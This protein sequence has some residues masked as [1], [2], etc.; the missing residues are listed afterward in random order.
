MDDKRQVRLTKKGTPLTDFALRLSPQ[1]ATKQGKR[2]NVL[3]S[4]T[5]LQIIDLLN[6]YDTLLCVNEL[7]QVL[8]KTPSAVS[9]HLRKLKDAGI[10]YVEKHQTYSYYRV[11]SDA[12]EKFWDYLEGF[13]SEK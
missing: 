8:N 5:R 9:Q 3:Q 2:W 1:E 4:P 13:V 7:A 10:V 6:R 11:G 12:F